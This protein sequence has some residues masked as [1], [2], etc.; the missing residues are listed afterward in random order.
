[1]RGYDIF[2]KKWKIPLYRVHVDKDDLNFVSKVVKRG[3]DW[4][5]G[6]EILTFEKNLANYVDTK[7]CVT[8]NS[9]TS[10]LHASLIAANI[11]KKNEVLVPS[12]SFIATVNST[13]MVDALPKFV[14][15]E[16]DTFG[17]DPK[18]ISKSI[19]KKT[20][21]IIPIHYAGLP[22]KIE[23]ICKISKK[24]NL[25]VVE[26][27][28]ESLGATIKNKKIGSFG[29]L[30]IFSF[31]GNK[32]LTTGEGGA[33]VTNS[34]KL[35]HRLV[36]IRSHGREESSNYF[37]SIKNP[38]Y[39]ILGYNWRMSS[40]TAALA[41]SQ[42]G[43]LEKLIR[44]RRKNAAYLTLNLQK[45]DEIQTPLEP[46]GYRHVYQMYSIRLSN[47]KLRDD[48][49]KFLA[50]K[51]IMTKIFFNPIHKSKFYKMNKVKINPSLKVTEKLAKEIL[52]LPM[53]PDLTKE[54]L[55][56]ICESIGEFLEK[57]H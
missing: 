22:C 24:H 33:V 46:K 8:F 2:M 44:M 57:N 9:G 28:A 11:N 15:I 12:F 37:S 23:E 4:A 31:A 54:E 49:S 14:D 42:L 6:P 25:L 56:Y 50:K 5:N 17:I 16:N 26:D 52:T 1:M 21:A 13:L 45:F 32:V 39:V 30:S 41:N 47:S 35:F 43:K 27:A 29:D 3:M 19:T 40:I 10:A 53:Y 18:K 55:N 51:G 38:E 36:L 48:L 20:K 34:N 7:Y